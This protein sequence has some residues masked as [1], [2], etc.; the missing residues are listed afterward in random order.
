MPLNTSRKR[1]LYKRASGCGLSIGDQ[2]PDGQTHR[3]RFFHSPPD[4]DISIEDVDSI[5]K[6]V[7]EAITSFL[8]TIPTADI[9][10]TH[11]IITNYHD[12]DAGGHL[13]TALGIAAAETWLDGYSQCYRTMLPK[14]DERTQSN[15]D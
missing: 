14:N 8:D 3:Y 6:N 13:Y 12:Y 4:N 1:N 10:I 11:Q 9:T 2:S 5:S 15:D 7:D